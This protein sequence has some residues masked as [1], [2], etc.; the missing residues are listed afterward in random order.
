MRKSGANSFRRYVAGASLFCATFFLLTGC[1]R[2]NNPEPADE[3]ELI[4]T[5]SLKFTEQGTTNAQTFTYRDI[6]GDGGQ[7]PTK[8]DAITLTAGKTYDL[9][10][11]FQDESKSPADDITAEINQKKDEHLVVYTPS[12]AS[13]LT[14]TITD[15]DSRNYPVGLTSTAKAGA[16]GTGILNVQ[17]RHQPPVN[18]QPVKNGTAT[19]GSD[20]VNLKFTLTVK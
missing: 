15:K 16:A 14:V 13:L 5:V 12:P 8:F 19:P 20:D 17:L 7:A 1:D 11:S 6:D 10:I 2:A 4:T 3:N 18:G 9:A